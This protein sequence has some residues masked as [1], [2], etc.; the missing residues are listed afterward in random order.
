MEARSNCVRRQLA[1]ESD[2]VVAEATSFAHE[3]D[4]AIDSV[5]LVQRLAQCGSKHLRGRRGRVSRQFDR[6]APP[7]IVAYV[8]ERKVPSNSEQPR[9]ASSFAAVRRCR[10]GDAEEHF[11]RQ[12]ARILVPDDTAQIAEHAVSMR[13]KEDIGVCHDATL[14]NKNTGL[15]RSSRPQVL[16]APCSRRE[17]GSDPGAAVGVRP[18]LVGSDPFLGVRLGSGS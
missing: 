9:T 14:S 8:V 12:L 16:R 7:A 2:L 4:I 5:Q 15:G 17:M 18:R 13:S 3:K 1:R 10:P 6:G 11:L